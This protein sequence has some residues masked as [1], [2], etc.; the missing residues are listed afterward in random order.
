MGIIEKLLSII[1]PEEKKLDKLLSLEYGLARNLLP[2]S[3]LRVKDILVL[4]DY[5][6]KMVRL[7]VKAMKFKNNIK[8]RKMLANIL[9]EEVLS[10]TCDIALF[11]GSSPLLLPMPMSKKEKR[12]RG[13]NQ[14]EELLSEIS[15][16]SKNNF[17]IQFDLL[18]KVRDTERQVKLSREE[19]V[20]N[21]KGCMQVFDPKNILKNRPV[22]ILDDIYTTGS[23]FAEARRALSQA[24]V[25]RVFGLFLAH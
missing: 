22:I 12:A 21:L 10:L 20:K 3:S 17:E 7:L 1:T 6:N 14:C 16:V 24:G 13:Y 8:A 19:R 23:T 18:Q 25:N 9:H 11:E 15:K 2:K 5:Q 4:F